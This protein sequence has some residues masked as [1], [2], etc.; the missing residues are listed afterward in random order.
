MKGGR[1]A[2]KDMEERGRKKQKEKAQVRPNKEM[3]LSLSRITCSSS[4]E[5]TAASS[6]GWYLVL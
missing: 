2:R 6:T 5:H 4:A 1:E 3:S